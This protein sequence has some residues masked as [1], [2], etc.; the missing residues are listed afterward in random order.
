MS[1]ERERDIERIKSK[2]EKKKKKGD[3]GEMDMSRVCLERPLFHSSTQTERHIF[4]HT[5]TTK[6]INQNC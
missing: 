6:L 2:D 3:Q 1:V 5:Q 4:S